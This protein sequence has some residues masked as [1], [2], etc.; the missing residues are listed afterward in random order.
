MGDPI[1][2]PYAK[3]APIEEVKTVE[4]LW[5]P[6]T[7]LTM[8]CNK[9]RAITWHRLIDWTDEEVTR[10]CVRCDTPRTDDIDFRGESR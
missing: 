4:N 8:T 5:K 7:F 2:N 10:K 9:C 6:P 1:P 3:W